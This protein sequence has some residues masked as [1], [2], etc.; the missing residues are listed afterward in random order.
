MQKELTRDYRY[1]EAIEKFSK[2][3][4]YM[5]VLP[6]DVPSVA[7]IQAAWVFNAF[8]EQIKPCIF[9]VDKN[10]ELAAF[11]S[12]D[13]YLTKRGK[14]CRIDMDLIDHKAQDYK[15]KVQKIV[16]EIESDY[17][18]DLVEALK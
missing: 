5:L 2:S 4:N 16:D 6:Y 18:R 8:P 3:K 14:L 10:I 1:E 13:K 12:E 7:R 17:I 11:M 9:I 15:T